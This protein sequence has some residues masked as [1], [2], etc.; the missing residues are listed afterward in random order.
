MTDSQTTTPVYLDLD[1]V[2]LVFKYYTI[3]VTVKVDLKITGVSNDTLTQRTYNV[4]FRGMNPD[5]EAEYNAFK[6]TPARLFFLNLS[7][8]NVPLEKWE[9]AYNGS[10]TVFRYRVAS[11]E[12][13]SYG[14][15]TVTVDPEETLVV[16]GY[17]EAQGDV[18]TVNKITSSVVAGTSLLLPIIALIVI[19]AI[20]VAVVRA[21]RHTVSEV[22]RRFVGRR[23]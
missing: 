3:L 14:G 23:A 11:T 18:V 10:H 9:R 15:F 13:Y 22:S 5:V 7:A 4:K 16:E 2:V 8:F 12:S 1:E 19:V 17:A 21:V 6:F 20:A